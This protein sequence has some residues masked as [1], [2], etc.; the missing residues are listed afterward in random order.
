MKWFMN[1]KLIA[2]KQIAFVWVTVKWYLK[3]AQSSV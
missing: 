2:E 1:T 3:I